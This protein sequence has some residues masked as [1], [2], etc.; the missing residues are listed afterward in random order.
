ML[1]KDELRLS[2]PTPLILALRMTDR[3]LIGNLGRS[4]SRR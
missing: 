2:M 3:R 4:F 1:L